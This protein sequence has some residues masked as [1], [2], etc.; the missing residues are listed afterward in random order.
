[1]P[2][3]ILMVYVSNYASWYKEVPVKYVN[4]EKYF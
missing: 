3:P 1:M 4:Y 2:E